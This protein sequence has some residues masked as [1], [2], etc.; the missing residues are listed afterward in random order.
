MTKSEYVHNCIIFFFFLSFKSYAGRFADEDMLLVLRQKEIKTMN[1]C[2]HPNV[3]RYL[4]S[5]ISGD[6]LWMVMPLLE[7]G[8][9][10]TGRLPSEMHFV[11]SPPFT[12]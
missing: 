9:R 7:A 2:Q 11:F 10:A 3:V 8:T 12:S 1:E 6:Q 4:T 5:F